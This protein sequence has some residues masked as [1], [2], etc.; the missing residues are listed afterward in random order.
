ML[1]A[2]KPDEAAR[3]LA[4]A[5]KVAPDNQHLLRTYEETKSQQGKFIPDTELKKAISSELPLS[6][7]SVRDF[8]LTASEKGGL[9]A[10]LL[11]DDQ[12]NELRKAQTAAVVPPVVPAAPSSDP[13]AGPV[14]ASLPAGCV[15]PLT[16][17]QEQGLRPGDVFR[18]CNNCP[19]MVVVP[20]GT[21]TMGSPNDE[22]YRR[23]E[24]GPQHQV[25][26]AK[27]FAT[28]RFAVTFAE[29]DAC[30]TDGGCS[31]RNDN[32]WGHGKQ[33]V[34][35]VTWSDAK[36]YVAWLSRKTGKNYRLLSEAQREYVTRAGT[37]T[38]FWWGTSITTEQANYDGTTYVQEGPG[39]YSVRG[40]DRQRTL[41]VDSFQPNPWG[42]YQVHGN[43]WEWTED[44]EH[45]NYDGAPMDG[46]AWVSDKIL[47]IS[48]AS[49]RL[50]A[51]P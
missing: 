17:L 19:E 45:R 35:N 33:P 27:P 38:P 15:A 11:T 6:A 10:V 4:K 5:W 20:S 32:G 18:E 9:P 22:K 34:I 51:R 13:C 28:G 1:Y 21:F 50:L 46:S 25:T 29:W 30:L 40:L 48:H 24:E 43:I 47:L 3:S 31:I 39:V 41:P 36:S 12:L 8:G 42:L 16:D 26:F 44:C 23:P 2:G 49:R 37:S 14:T 7:E